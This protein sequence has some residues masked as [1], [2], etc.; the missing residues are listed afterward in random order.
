MDMSE[1]VTQWVF[2]ERERRLRRSE[3]GYAMALAS[4]AGA[5]LLTDDKGRR[6]WKHDGDPEKVAAVTRAQNAQARYQVAASR[7]RSLRGAITRR[8]K[9]RPEPDAALQADY[10]AM[11]IDLRG[12]W[13][14]ARE[15]GIG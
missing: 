13:A 2:A 1:R 3:R 8:V 10:A 12:D 15:Y 4:H 5:E 9:I 7:A 6:V 14:S 11:A